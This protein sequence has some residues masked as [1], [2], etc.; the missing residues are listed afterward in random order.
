LPGLVY[1]LTLLRKR[2]S[3]AS[4]RVMSRVV[5][6]HFIKINFQ[7]IINEHVKRI[8]VIKLGLAAQPVNIGVIC[9]R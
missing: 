8:H 6:T 5:V 1:P 7:I 9:V 4:R 3:A 2:I